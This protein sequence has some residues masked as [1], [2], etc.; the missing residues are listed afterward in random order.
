MAYDED[1]DTTHTPSSGGVAPTAWGTAI[2]ANFADMGAWTAYTPT[3]TAAT[4]NPTIG[5][6]TISGS[7]QLRGKFLIWRVELTMGST[8][9]FGSGGYRFS[10]PATLASSRL[11]TNG[12][13]ICFDNSA[14]SFYPMQIYKQAT[15]TTAFVDAGSGSVGGP[16]VPFTF[17]TSDEIWFTGIAEL[18]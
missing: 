8:T 17:A 18:P 2:N 4:S 10:T 7:Y 1:L 9:T 3:W 11:A 12:F 5:N 13:G 15:T 6:G 14:T 16:T